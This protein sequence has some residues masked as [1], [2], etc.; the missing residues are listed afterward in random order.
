VESTTNSYSGTFTQTNKNTAVVK[1][2][3]QILNLHYLH[4]EMLF[5]KFKEHNRVNQMNQWIIIRT[6]WLTDW[7]IWKRDILILLDLIVTVHHYSLGKKIVCHWAG[8]IIFKRGDLPSCY[9]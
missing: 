3:G 5:S 8:S 1:F 2:D 6:N 9:W 7:T 4:K